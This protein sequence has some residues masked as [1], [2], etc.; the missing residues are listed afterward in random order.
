MSRK[1][2]A[3]LTMEEGATKEHLDKMDWELR[4]LQF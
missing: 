3:S 2:R 4:K 1:Q